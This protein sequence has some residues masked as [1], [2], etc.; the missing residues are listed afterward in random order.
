MFD[1]SCEVMLQDLYKELEK[2]GCSEGL[3]SSAREK[4]LE[5]QAQVGNLVQ[6]VSWLENAIDDADCEEIMLEYQ[7]IWSAFF[8]SGAQD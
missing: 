4:F 1:V 6:R 7:K 2:E 3:K 5:I 8:W